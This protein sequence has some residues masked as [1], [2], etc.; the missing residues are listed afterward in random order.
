[1]GPEMSST[2]KNTATSAL[3]MDQ[4]DGE[5]TKHLNIQMALPIQVAGHP[6]SHLNSKDPTQRSQRSKGSQKGITTPLSQTLRAGSSQLF[7]PLSKSY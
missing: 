2:N 3:G 4:M 6:P 5:A 7:F 1:M